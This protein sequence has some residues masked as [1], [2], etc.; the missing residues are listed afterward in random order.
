MLVRVFSI[1]LVISLSTAGMVVASRAAPGD[2]W[3][4]SPTAQSVGDDAPDQVDP[5]GKAEPQSIEP[6]GP[7]WSV[8]DPPP[9][10]ELFGAQWIE[11]PT[12]RGARLLGAVYRPQVEESRPLVVLLHG[13]HGFMQQYV[14]LAKDL[15]D[16]GFVTLA[17]CLFSNHAADRTS[18]PIECPNAPM[19]REPREQLPEVEA[20]V[21][22]GRGLPG[23][24]AERT[25]LFGH[26]RGASAALWYAAVVGDARAIVL[27]SGGYSD[28]LATAAQTVTVPLLMLHGTADSQRGGGGPNSTIQR[29]QALEAQ[30]LASG[31]D[32]S[33]TYYPGADHIDFWRIPAQRADSF[34]RIVAFY[35]ERL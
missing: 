6:L 25:G 35:N 13:N 24:D 3:A 10:T 31:G 9:G 29:A 16:A 8:V 14:Q 11:V 4:L 34:A 1:A 5:Q 20:L 12:A 18:P 27:N 30:V 19:K 23:V 15:A 26:S 21:A 33:A 2:A 32:I 28:A 7:L 22:A 17:G